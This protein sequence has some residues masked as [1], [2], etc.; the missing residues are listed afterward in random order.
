MK[1]ATNW[2][3][4]FPCF[5]FLPSGNPFLRTTKNIINVIQAPPDNRGFLSYAPSTQSWEMRSV[6]DVL[7]GIF[8]KDGQIVWERKSAKSNQLVGVLIAVLL[9]PAAVEVVH[10]S[11]SSAGD[12]N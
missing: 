3:A 5:S 11:K 4:M 7:L 9:F 8:I 6:H 1:N 2:C 12:K 10:R